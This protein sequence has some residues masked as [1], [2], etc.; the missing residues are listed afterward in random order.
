MEPE[1]FFAFLGLV[2]WF[3]FK[4]IW[5]IISVILNNSLFYCFKNIADILKSELII[6][7]KGFSLDS[8]P[9]HSEKT[10]S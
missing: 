7:F 4:D 6:T 2:F 5:R 10:Y 1:I 8:I 9:I 3:I